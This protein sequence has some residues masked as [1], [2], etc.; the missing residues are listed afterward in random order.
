MEISS[1]INDFQAMTVHQKPITAPVEV[2]E[3]LI[4]QGGE[5]A[6]SSEKQNTISNAK[7]EKSAQD[8][9]QT[10]E[11]NNTQASVAV[12][13]LGA[14]A[15]QSQTE[16]YL[17]V[18]TQSEESSKSSTASA[19]ESLRNVQKQNNE[20]EAYVAYKEN[21]NNPVESFARGLAE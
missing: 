10:Q 5:V 15:E 4:S 2:Q 9:V 18:A 20:L 16:I 17:A 19:V 3:N 12:D 11:Q 14:K 1:Q 8:A 21:Q 6:L 7:D 13:Y